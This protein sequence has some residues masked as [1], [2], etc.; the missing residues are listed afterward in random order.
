[1]MLGEYCGELMNITQDLMEEATRRVLSMDFVGLTDAFN[2]TVC[3][4]HHQYVGMG[5]SDFINM[6]K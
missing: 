4:F 6:M 2:A 5:V 3:L 1:M